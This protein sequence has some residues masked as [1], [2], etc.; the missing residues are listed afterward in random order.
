[1]HRSG[2]IL[3]GCLRVIR[4]LLRNVFDTPLHIPWRTVSQEC[5]AL[6]PLILLVTKLASAT[7]HRSFW[8]SQCPTSTIS[9]DETSHEQGQK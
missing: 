5:L 8:Q 3:V 9:S 2:E 1:M 4:H 6:H 7:V